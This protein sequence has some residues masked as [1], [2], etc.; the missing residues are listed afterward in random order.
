M[1]G[2]L[3]SWS[4]EPENCVFPEPKIVENIKT[5]E[6]KMEADV[7][8]SVEQI[9]AAIESA[10]APIKAELAEVKAQ[11]QQLKQASIK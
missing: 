5:S 10:L 2:A 1:I 6:D 7:T 8:L 11:L 9:N 3:K 4:H